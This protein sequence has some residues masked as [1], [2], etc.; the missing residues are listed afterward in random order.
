MSNTEKD[1]IDLPVHWIS[2]EARYK[3]IEHMISTRTIT[4]LARILGISP[5]AVRKYIN[6]ISYPSDEVVLR[7][8][9]SSA[10]YERDAVMAIII[11]DL[12]E[13]ISRLYDK[14]EEKYR[15]EIKNKLLGIIG[16]YFP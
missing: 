2:R 16:L 8:I 10:M 9:I 14:V 1:G 3:I 6:R 7:A 15:R 4:E 11:D 5:T 13:T 12:I